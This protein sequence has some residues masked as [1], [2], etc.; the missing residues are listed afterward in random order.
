VTQQQS[1]SNGRVGERAIRAVLATVPYEPEEIDRLRQAVVLA[2]FIHCSS[3][4]D[5]CIADALKTVDV[6]IIP[7]D[8]DDRHIG[9]PHLHW[10]HCDHSGL[11]RSARREVFE[12]VMIV[13]GSAGRSA[14]ALAQHA[15]YFALALT[16][17]ARKL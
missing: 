10:V 3:T 1:S 6:A 5:A 15:F 12:R 4:D 16:F 8:L 17:D 14:A 2:E 13:T 7:E 11:T 9:A